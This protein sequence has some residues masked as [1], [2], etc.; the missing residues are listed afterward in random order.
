MSAIVIEDLLGRALDA[1]AD[2]FDAKHEGAFRLF[3]GFWEGYPPFVAD[4]YGR[5]LLLHN[6]AKVPEDA[7]GLC[8]SRTRFLFGSTFRGWRGLWSRR[9]VGRRLKLKTA[10]WFGVRQWQIAWWSMTLSTP[11]I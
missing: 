10:V 6:Y 7:A 1:R 4:L 11:L 8:A 5:T 3:N 9:D 2:L